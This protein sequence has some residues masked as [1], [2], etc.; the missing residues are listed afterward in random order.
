MDAFV[1]YGSNFNVTYSFFDNVGFT[2]CLDA[3]GKLRVVQEIV[4]RFKDREDWGRGV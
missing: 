2:T 4:N 1:L 3:E